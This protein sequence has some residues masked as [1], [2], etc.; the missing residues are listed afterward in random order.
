MSINREGNSAT[1][2]VEPL[3]SRAL[4]RS[5]HALNNDF[6]QLVDQSPP[7]TTRRAFGLKADLI[8]N[9]RQLPAPNRWQ[10]SG[11]ACS[12]FTLRLADAWFWRTAADC[13]VED[14]ASGQAAYADTSAR[15]AFIAD[16]VFFAWHLAHAAP[17]V[18]RMSFGMTE[19]VAGVVR[20]LS[21]QQIR[22]FAQS[23]AFPLAARWPDNQ[24]FWPDLIRFA[25]PDTAREL[26]ATHLLGTQLLAAELAPAPR[27]PAT[28]DWRLAR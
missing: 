1:R 2:T 28:G 23:A 6:L 27:Q 10:L 5:V 17:L 8:Q 14:A 22:R 24:C 9:L 13:R 7:L 4:L 11:S 12:L 20:A 16:A 19:E 15:T 26:E 18:G 3:L 25:Q 21:L